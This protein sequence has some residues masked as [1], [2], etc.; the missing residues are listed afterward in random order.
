M[1]LRMTR[2][3]GSSAARCLIMALALGLAYTAVAWA[4]TIQNPRRIAEGPGGQLLVSDRSGSIVALDKTS[5]QPLWSFQLPAEGAPFGLATSNRLVFVGNTESRNVEVYRLTGSQGGS[6]TLRFAYNLGGTPAGEMGTIQNPISIATDRKEKLV[7]VLDGAAKM[8][9]VFDQKGAFLRDFAPVDGDG[10]VLSPVSLEVD[11]IRGEVLVADYGDPSGSSVA[12]APARI[13]IYGYD[14]T[15]RDQIDGTGFFGS[16]FVFRRVQGMATSADGRIFA[17]D[18]LGSRILVLDR[19]TGELKEALGT[20]GQEPGQ[21]MIPTDV[22]LDQ[23]TGDLF[24]V[25][26]RGGRRVEVIRGVGG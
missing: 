19:S 24:I 20:Q 7:F 17:T 5:L 12:S 11:P 23:D 6:K 22:L 13:L 25:N 8:V 16:N 10:E 15:L 1:L 26:N 2:W 21:L 9:K 14:G 18:P 4:Q 3:P